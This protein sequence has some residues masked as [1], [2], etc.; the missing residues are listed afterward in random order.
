MITM[1][2]KKQLWILGILGVLSVDCGTTTVTVPVMRPAEVN[3]GKLKKIAIGRV[4]G[5]GASD[6]EGILINELLETR[7]FEVLDR[8]NL[9][10]ILREYRLTMSELIDEKTALEL[11]KF[12]GAAGLI[13]ARVSE[14]KYEEEIIQ[15]PPYKDKE[16]RE[17]S[18]YARNGRGIVIVNFRITDLT[19]GKYIFSKDMTHTESAQTTATD[20][21]PVLIDGEDVL[22]SA[23][24]TVVRQFI[25]RITPHWEDV[26]VRFLTDSDVPELES[27]VSFAKV[28]E[29][30][31]AIDV[32]KSSTEKYRGSKNLHKVYFDLGV[33]LEYSLQFGEALEALHK[34]YE[35]DD[36]SDYMR[37]METCKRLE[38][39]NKK[40]QEQLNE[41]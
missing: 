35:L 30:G 5:R 20:K 31:K 33:A 12:V 15:D 32:F 16:G 23:R 11:G 21:H 6:L 19:T 26:Q 9:D 41:Q 36:D 1:L 3:M 14:Y 27:G 24:K 37:E 34:A 25:R 39:E 4:T 17:H 18:R 2:N 7:A 8:D 13:S 28:R 10:R 22:K 29:W 40:L 38:R